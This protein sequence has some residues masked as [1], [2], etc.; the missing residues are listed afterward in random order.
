MIRFGRVHKKLA[1]GLHTINNC[2]DK[3]VVVDMRLNQIKA[4]QIFTTK[5]NLTIKMSSF[6][7][8]R[9]THP[10]IFWFTLESYNTM[11]V[12][13]ISGVLCT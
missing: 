7:T 9:I 5:D 4:S 3:V 13:L 2:T 11:L 12:Q 10:E 1:P 6:G 8:W